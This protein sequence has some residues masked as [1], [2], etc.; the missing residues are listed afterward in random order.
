[1][2]WDAV[3]ME[4]VTLR[5]HSGGARNIFH[6][7]REPRVYFRCARCICWACCCACCNACCCGDICGGCGWAI[8][9]DGGVFTCCEACS[10]NARRR[11]T[12]EATASKRRCSS[13]GVGFTTT[14]C[15][16]AGGTLVICGGGGGAMF[17]IAEPEE[18]TFDCGNASVSVR[19]WC[20]TTTV[21]K[22]GA[23]CFTVTSK[24]VSCSFNFTHVPVF[25]AAS[26]KRNFTPSEVSLNPRY[27]IGAA[28]AGAAAAAAE[29]GGIN[30]EADGACAT[31][32]PDHSSARPPTA[33]LRK[34]LGKT[35]DM[36][37]VAK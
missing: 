29:A 27:W 34:E 11:A 22:S 30:G 20:K 6:S 28:A 18:D 32:A 14:A 1:M 25:F 12:S 33:R 13:A 8:G 4:R 37:R 23:L 26:T 7:A 15:V 35:G 19:P 3:D 36:A 31:N 17:C 5:A 16:T 21:L 10:R 2:D 9:A 24:V